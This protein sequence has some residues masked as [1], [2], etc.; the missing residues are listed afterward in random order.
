MHH[1]AGG[2]VCILTINVDEHRQIAA[3]LELTALPA[4]ALFE[5]GEFRRF[6][7]GVGTKEEIL[8]HVGLTPQ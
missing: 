1:V 5:H 4:L 3:E 6:I 8:K 7:G 2:R